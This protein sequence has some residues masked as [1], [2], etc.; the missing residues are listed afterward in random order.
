MI[1]QKDIA[2][3]LEMSKNLADYCK[4]KKNKTVDTT[5]LFLMMSL[6]SYMIQYAITGSITKEF[7]DKKVKDGSKRYK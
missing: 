3:C 1:D 4:D 5:K 2:Y 7:V 6:I